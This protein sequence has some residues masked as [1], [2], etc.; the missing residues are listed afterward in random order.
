MLI[1][2]LQNSNTDVRRGPAEA[3]GLLGG[4]SSAAATAEQVAARDVDE[5]VRKT[6]AAA[7]DRINGTAPEARPQRRPAKMA[8]QDHASAIFDNPRPYAAIRLASR[9]IARVAVI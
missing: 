9:A 4:P 5:T 3:L 1:I 2:G 7:L 6:T 8:E